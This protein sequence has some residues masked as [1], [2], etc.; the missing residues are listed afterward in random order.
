MVNFAG[1]YMPVQYE[2]VNAEHQF[3]RQAV[4]VFDISHMGEILVIGNKA[5]DFLQWVTSNDVSQLKIGNIQYSYL[6]NNTGGIV[7]DILVYRLDD[8]KFMLVV[9]ASNLEKDWKWLNQKNKWNVELLN[10][11]DE[12]SLLA[13]Q[14]PQSL[15]LLQ[16]LTSFNLSELKYYN[17]ILGKI[18]EINDII[19]S[20]TGYTGELGFELY[21]KNKY[22]KQL[23]NALFS[24]DC[25][26]KPIGLAA[27]DTLRL[28][29]GF[30]LYGNDI[31]EN[32]SP[33]EAGLAW[34]TKFSKSF[35]N[36]DNLK[37][38]KEEGTKRSLI[39][40]ELL[41]RGI[42]RKGYLIV[43][44]DGIEIGI[45]TSGTMSPTLKKAIA[46]GYVLSEYKKLGKEVYI[47]IRHKKIKAKF[48]NLPFVQ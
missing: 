31:D 44:T 37:K 41:E 18:A 40:L 23:W 34:I 45:I 32:T 27:R 12:Y 30:C 22:V 6:P 11:S 14:G 4:G 15:T 36:S 47:I 38:Q 26:L 20:R 42:A 10:K 43:D 28:E 3:V 16:Q 2:G 5:E 13:L 1:Y 25:E 8:N 48:V 39:G 21:V 33:I 46:I 17:F 19:I 9:N 7:D 29:K 24:T 35:I